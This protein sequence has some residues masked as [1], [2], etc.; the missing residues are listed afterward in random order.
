MKIFLLLLLPSLS[1]AVTNFGHLVDR[2]GDGQIVVATIGSS[3]TQHWITGVQPWPEQLNLGV[4]VTVINYGLGGTT[5]IDGPYHPNS[6]IHQLQ[7]ALAAT[8]KPDTVIAAFLTNDVTLDYFTGLAPWAPDAAV[9]AYQDVINLAGSNIDVWFLLA[10]PWCA[11]YEDVNNSVYAFN[12]A[13]RDAFPL[14][15]IEQPLLSCATDYYTDPIHLNQ[16]GQLKTAKRVR[17]CILHKY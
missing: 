3:N 14:Q 9:V 13:I 2:N 6:A 7:T 11:P 10:P 16:V 17:A 4:G 15:T 5:A 8:P 1:F 12:T